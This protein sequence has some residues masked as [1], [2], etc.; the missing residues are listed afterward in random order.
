MF[1]YGNYEISYGNSPRLVQYLVTGKKFMQFRKAMFQNKQKYL[2]TQI[3]LIIKTDMATLSE[4]SKFNIEFKI[5][6]KKYKLTSN[7]SI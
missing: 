6:K 3:L 7:Q 4:I 5:I 2:H 1:L